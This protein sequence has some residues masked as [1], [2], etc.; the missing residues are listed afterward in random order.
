MT[1][2]MGLRDGLM[3]GAFITLKVTDIG[4]FASNVIKASGR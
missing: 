4:G 2:I 3:D 1:S